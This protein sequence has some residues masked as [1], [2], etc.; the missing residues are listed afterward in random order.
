MK[1]S[2]G[3]TLIELM[4]GMVILAAAIAG[5]LSFFIFQSQRGHESFRDKSTDEMV[6]SALALLTRDVHS[7]GFGCVTQRPKLASLIRRVA[8]YPD[9][10]YVSYSEYLD[11]QYHDR[12]TGL[13]YLRSNSI[14]CEGVVDV[15]YQGYVKLTDITNLRLFAIPKRNSATLNTNVGAILTTPTATVKD[16]L[17]EPIPCDVNVKGSTAVDNIT[18]L[19]TQDWTFPI[20]APTGWTLS[21]G[22]T[23]IPAVSYK[24]RYYRSDGTL[25]TGTPPSDLY[26]NTTGTIFG[27]L[28][29]N[30]GPEA[31]PYGVPLIGWSP[32]GGNP[33]INVKNFTIRRQYAD[34]G[35][36]VA[37]SSKGE[38]EEGFVPGGASF[39]DAKNVR[40]MEISLTYQ[41]NVS[42]ETV[43][44]GSS[45][46]KPKAAWSQPMT[47]VIRISPRHMA[48]L[49]S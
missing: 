34:G 40:V 23:A 48:L 45:S 27:S 6:F 35:W 5:A 15:T 43:Q 1:N 16:P 37:N 41:T 38:I 26:E 21:V 9:E 2:K 32:K 28:W 17:P 49:G 42:K 4:V 3:F 11:M 29:R 33:F 20:T 31:N 46:S 12:D 19:G 10:L 44:S 22:D 7:S 25:Y 36:D 18:I 14:F 47:R 24:V 39:K 8:N 30:R 13:S